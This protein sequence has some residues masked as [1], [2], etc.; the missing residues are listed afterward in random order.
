MASSS[1]PAAPASRDRGVR[2]S[3]TRPVVDRARGRSWV[4]QR[5]SAGKC[6]ARAYSRPPGPSAT[7]SEPGATSQRTHPWAS[8]NRA[9]LSRSF[10]RLGPVGPPSGPHQGLGVRAVLRPAFAPGAHESCPHQARGPSLARDTRRR[11][12]PLA[13]TMRRSIHDNRRE[14]ATQVIYCSFD[15]MDSPASRPVRPTRADPGGTQ[16]P[17][18]QPRDDAAPAAR[19]V[20]PSGEPMD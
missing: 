7:D 10:G 19:A 20:V 11:P 2:S 6:E 17:G 8:V 4:A 1:Q 18:S 15:L 16:V 14:A 13:P 3:T 12:I 9:M 5:A